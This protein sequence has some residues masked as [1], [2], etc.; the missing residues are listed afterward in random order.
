MATEA[1]HQA[2]VIKW[3]Q[4]PHIRAR[5]PELALLFHIPNGGTRD[6]VEGKHLKQ[7]GVKKG[8]PDLCLPVPKGIYHALYIEMKTEKGRTTSDQE[9]WGN[10]LLLQGNMWEVCHGWESAVRVLEWYLNLTEGAS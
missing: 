1:Q 2:A 7:Q 5:Y 8:V 10:S 9:W 6:A 4:Q 3:S